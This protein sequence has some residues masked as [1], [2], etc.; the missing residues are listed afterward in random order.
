MRIL[1]AVSIPFP[2][3]GANTR[4]ISTI[5]RE[6]V[7]QGEQVSL[8]IPFARESVPKKQII[9]GFE[10][11]WCYIPKSKEKII[12][13]N[14]RI[15]F[16]IQVISRIQFL[17]KFIFLSLVDKY[18]WVYL[19]QPFPDGMLAA[20]IAKITGH[21]VCSE[22]VDRL[23]LENWPGYLGKIIYFSL[24]VADFITARLSSVI[25]VISSILEQRYRRIAR[26]ASIIV[27]PSLV[28]VKIFK[29]LDTPNDNFDLNLL[30]FK[31]V[32]YSGSLSKHQGV[33]I[34]IEAMSLVVK[35]YENVQLI[36]AGSCLAIDSDN[37]SSLIS[38][39]NLGNNVTY[40]G[41]IPLNEVIDLLRSSD[42]LV[43]PKLDHPI[44]HAGFSTKLSE[45]LAVGKPV[46][47]SRVGDVPL[48]LK[49]KINAML[50]EPGSVS[51]LALNISLLL[52]DEKLAEQISKQGRALA[53]E[54]FDAEINVNKMIKL[55]SEIHFAA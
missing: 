10:V 4:R 32:V 16:S 13:L 1:F 18:D 19:Y 45:Y 15:R 26:H 3:G 5:A 17:I 52:N 23:S 6:M 35:R 9:N 11:I 37:I 34:L 46:V 8:L 50:C 40:L 53:Q 31:K 25:F 38:K 7:N 47:V 49:H 14:G 27:I 51:D 22:F 28:D 36:I 33:S 41:S 44:N 2:E 21:K 43:A 54:A 29:P 42:V 12:S 24:V 39:F 55:L 48:Y 20:F 30:D